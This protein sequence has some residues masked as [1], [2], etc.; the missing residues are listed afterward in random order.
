MATKRLSRKERDRLRHRQEI[1]SKALKLF[2]ERGFHNVS[3]QQI[4]EAS[5]FAV[6]TLYN[7]FENKESLFDELMRMCEE[8]I[9]EA[10]VAVLD[11]PGTEVDRLTRYIR[12]APDMIEVHAPF[13]KLFVSELGTRGVKLSQNRDKEHFDSMIY[14]RLEQ[15][16]ADGIRKGHFRPVDPAIT[17][18]ALSSISETLAL[19][20]ADRFDKN[21]AKEIFDK[22]EH[23]FIGGLLRPGGA[24]R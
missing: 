13:I 18:K 22:I 15:L 14:A 7:F 24:N 3:M 8:R 10:L 20:M 11:A 4:A 5:E 1:L 21:E 2:T 16:L 9:I 12:Y 23:L 6:G 17:A 19:E